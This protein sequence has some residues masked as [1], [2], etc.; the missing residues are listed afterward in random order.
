MYGEAIAR[1]KEKLPLSARARVL[2][3]LSEARRGREEASHE[4]SR[5]SARDRD[6]FLVP[7][8]VMP[9]RASNV[10]IV[11]SRVSC[12]HVREPVAW[13]IPTRDLERNA[14]VCS[15]LRC[16]CIAVRAHRRD[17]AARVRAYL[18]RVRLCPTCVYTYTHVD[19]LRGCVRERQH[20]IIGRRPPSQWIEALISLLRCK[21]R[22]VRCCTELHSN[23][24]M[25]CVHV[26]WRVGVDIR[27]DRNP[28][29]SATKS[30]L[31]IN[32]QIARLNVSKQI[33][34]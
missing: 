4:I 13:S 26:I 22:A 28:L 17:G 6:F 11:R 16:I 19:L 15:D 2:F 20:E 21:L 7:G 25:V 24:E 33:R 34:I 1:L 10:S 31:K 30:K 3:Q 9:L 32:F 29:N 14:R 23:V 18:Y 27:A 8:R 5:L 12:I